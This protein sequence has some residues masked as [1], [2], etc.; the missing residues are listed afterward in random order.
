MEN[1]SDFADE[2]TG[3]K[4][5][6]GRLTAFATM[7]AG[8]AEFAERN[9]LSVL[10]YAAL[11]I[12][13]LVLV[14]SLGFLL[15]GLV[16]Q[17]GSNKVDAKPVTVSVRDV[18]PSQPESGTTPTATDPSRKLQPLDSAIRRRTAAIYRSAFKVYERPG[19]IVD[20]EKVIAQVWPEDRR[21]Y[22]ENLVGSLLVDAGGVPFPDG[23]AISLD[24]LNAV[25]SAAKTVDFKKVLS[26]YK[27]AKEVK[28]CRDELQ[29]RPRTYRAW[30]SFSTSCSD[31][32]ESPIGCSV[33]R[34]ENE[35]FVTSVCKM[36]FPDN[37][38]APSVEFAEAIDRYAHSASAAVDRA[39]ID[40]DE[41]TA[42]QK[43]R[44]LNGQ[45]NIIDSGKLF[46]GF[47]AVMFLYLLIAMERHH[48]NLK[49]L[50]KQSKPSDLSS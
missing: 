6:K 1:V 38:D 42:R 2:P 3:A 21:R 20:E 32:Y 22:F 27:A 25:E 47:L 13:T 35:P 5:F 10:R 24:A 45:A 37:L 48:R 16:R 9:Y 19:A 40:A 7:L 39:Q 30:D 18:L 34:T 31:W 4:K 26:A 17:I 41:A 28:V 50:I 11:F 23:K 36:K 46:M 44:K 15:T 43:G 8:R 49:L 33:T 12:A 29:T 14:I